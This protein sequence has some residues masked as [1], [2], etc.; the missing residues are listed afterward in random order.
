VSSL[1]LKVLFSFLSLLVVLG[2]I[3]YIGMN[4]F[5][6]DFYYGKKIE[7]MSQM[8]A[9]INT[10]YKVSHSEDEALMNI[11]YLGYHFE[12]K[13]SIYDKDTKMIVFDSKRYEYT[14]GTI[15]DEISYKDYTAYVYVTKYP[16]EGARWL[17]YIDQLDNSK[18]ALMQIPVV[19]IEEAIHVIQ[20]FFSL[21]MLIS[22]GIAII[23]S[24]YLSNTITNPIK[25]IHKVANSIGNLEF[26][27]KYSG[28]SK[29]EIGQLGNRLNQISQTLKSTIDELHIEIEKE[30]NVDRLR[31]R[32]VAQ[33]S[34][35]LQTPIS[36]ITS[37]IEAIE[38]HL[39]NDDEIDMYHE[40]IRDESDKMSRIIKDLL[41]L[42]QLEAK[43]LNFK[44]TSVELT[45]FITSL[46]SRYALIAKQKGIE[47]TYD[48]A[49]KDEVYFSGDE[50]RLEQ[51]ITNIL[52]NAIKHS[53]QYIR[54]D[55]TQVG[56]SLILKVENSGNPID[57]TD[58]PHLFESFYKGKTSLKKE[59]TGLG[60]SIAAQIFEQHQMAYQVYNSQD[61]VVFEIMFTL[62]NR[63]AKQN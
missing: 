11:E 31:R 52:S 48:T 15:V 28:K 34:H 2:L 59:G 32:F 54:V 58:L 19:A 16:V 42:T 23:V 60:L 51:G 6:K 55:L 40:I 63:I 43:T 38:D 46:C 57:E 49:L 5:I 14:A 39:V 47:F 26:D 7:A 53:T 36:I 18:I 29:D 13:I 4:F 8:L 27:A 61:G 21:L 10:M 44:M 56:D 41:Q 35:E 30:K 24:I 17:V 3:I 25:K 22:I 37:H 50:L 33:V 1:R 20:S 12:G 9:Q 62:K 45:T